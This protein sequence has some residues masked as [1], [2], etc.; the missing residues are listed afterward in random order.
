MRKKPN[1]QLE[2]SGWLEGS[3]NFYFLIPQ[4]QCCQLQPWDSGPR[5]AITMFTFAE[6]IVKNH[7]SIFG[8]ISFP[9]MCAQT[10]IWTTFLKTFYAYDQNIDFFKRIVIFCDCFSFLSC[11]NFCWQHCPARRDSMFHLQGYSWQLRP[12]RL[13]K[14]IV[15]TQC[16]IISCSD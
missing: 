8:K 16:I 10:L 14:L 13:F 6:I 7:F 15:A 5:M 4:Q 3:I 11:W 12:G 2:C 1:I 9:K